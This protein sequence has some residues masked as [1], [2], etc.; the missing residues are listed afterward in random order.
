MASRQLLTLQME[1]HMLE[2]SWS[3]EHVELVMGLVEVCPGPKGQA[4]K[5]LMQKLGNPRQFFLQPPA[6]HCSSQSSSVLHAPASPHTPATK[7]YGMLMLTNS[8]RMS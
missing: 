6:S 1:G 3:T 5:P 4:H 7:K 8:L 2:Q